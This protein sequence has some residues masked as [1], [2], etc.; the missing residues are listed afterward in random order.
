MVVLF[1]VDGN[2]VMSSEVGA[3]LPTVEED[4]VILPKV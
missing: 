1:Q 4:R 3:K 2:I